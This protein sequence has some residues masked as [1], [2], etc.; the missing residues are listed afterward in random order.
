MAQDKTTQAL[1]DLLVSIL[2]ERNG[3]ETATTEAPVVES[4]EAESLKTKA[5]S[6]AAG[7]T[8]AELLAK[9]IQSLADKETTEETPAAPVVE[10]VETESLK[11]KASSGAE[12]TTDL[13]KQIA[14]KLLT[15]DDGSDAPAAAPVVESVETESLK[16]KASS[17]SL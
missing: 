13:I 14:A 9:T 17:G 5:S 11:T 1:A 12:S 3:G 2:Q 6:G 4:V 16:T 10:S 7:D 8:M 15:K